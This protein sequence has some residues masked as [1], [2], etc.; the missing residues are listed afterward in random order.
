[1]PYHSQLPSIVRG[2]II[3]V[4]VPTG[5]FRCFNLNLSRYF[6]PPLYV[7][8]YIPQFNKPPTHRSVCLIYAS[9]RFLHPTLHRNHSPS[10]T[11]TPTP[12][13]NYMYPAPCTPLHTIHPPRFTSIHSAP[14]GS[15]HTAARP[16]GN[17]NARAGRYDGETHMHA[18]DRSVQPIKLRGGGGEG[19]TRIVTR[20]MYVCPSAN[21]ELAVWRYIHVF[22]TGIYV[23]V[24]RRCRR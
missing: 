17:G 13:A 5:L 23:D 16:P 9:P 4:V 10:L 18:H 3:A 11:P 21:S 7:I 15:G 6:S 1:M 20:W 24:T 8:T 19:A 12:A 14:T 2:I 22:S